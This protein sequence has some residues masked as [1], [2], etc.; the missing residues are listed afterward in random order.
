MFIS[1]TLRFGEHGS[2]DNQIISTIT[3]NITACEAVAEV[4]AN[5]GTADVFDNL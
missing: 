5:L 2:T 4:R 3:I 1:I